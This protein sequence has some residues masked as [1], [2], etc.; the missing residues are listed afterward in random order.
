MQKEE[1]LYCTYQRIKK[2]LYR[3]L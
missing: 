2:F 3:T 1:G